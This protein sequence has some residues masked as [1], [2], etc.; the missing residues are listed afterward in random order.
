MI[1]IGN[2]SEAQV[3]P[4]VNTNTGQPPDKKQSAKEKEE[5]A[6]YYY[7]NNDF[8]KASPLFKELYKENPSLFNYAYY[9]NCLMTLGQ[10]D[11]TEKLVKQ[12][13]KKNQHN[14]KYKVDLGYVYIQQDKP[15]KAKKEF[16]KLIN[17]LPANRNMVLQLANAFMTKRLNDYA[18]TTYLKGRELLAQSYAFH[19]ELAR[20]YQMT[21]DFEAMTEEYLN[22]LETDPSK[23]NHV[24]NRLQSAL[25]NDN[26]GKVSESIRVSLLTRSQKD[27]DNRSLAEMMLWLSIQQKDF[28]FA[29]IQA[30]SYD[31]RFHDNGLTVFSLAGLCLTH[32]DFEV[33][34]EGYDYII[35][36]GPDNAYYN[37]SRFGQL[38]ARFLK[39]THELAYQQK[40]LDD[41]EEDYFTAIME[42]GFAPS[43]IPL[44]RDLAHLNAFYKHDIE[45]AISILEIAIGINGA[46][47]NEIAECKIELADI[48]IIT[49][50]VWESSLL[51]SQVEKTMRNDAVGHL[52]KLK[53]ARLSYYVGEFEWAKA[54]LDVLKAATSKMIA[55]DA[56]EL[57]LLIN[58]NMD[59]DST[60]TGLIYFSEAGLLMYQNQDS[61]ALITLDSINM[62]GLSHPLRDEV[63]LK[64]ADIYIKNNHYDVADSLLALLIKLYPDE[65]LADN[66]LFR[67]AELQETIFG[68]S[69]LAMELYQELLINYPGSLLTT[70]ARRRFRALRGDDVDS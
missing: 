40:E 69:D 11:E 13:I 55:N 50:G 18:I 16:D 45:E 21:G 9:S 17:T 26:E 41:L 52:A 28:G 42:A 12:H 27:P 48:Y 34:I 8:E 10:F 23:V 36:K 31:K 6:I 3:F 24:Q 70:E 49:G 7:R 58:D 63:L 51:Y 46:S 62:I 35:H 60:Y 44:R 68:N 66:A 30:I 14:I 57:S 43:S 53:N 32:D 61:L 29:L 5:L 64:K 33:A 65:I 19:D 59:A 25:K 2:K 67:R 22:L 1:S 37:E 4:Q 47:R 56:M 54:Q 15:A 39:I 38:R 20:L